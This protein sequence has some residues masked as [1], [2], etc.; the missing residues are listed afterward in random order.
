MMK[1]FQLA[2][3]SAILLVSCALAA[4]EVTHENHH[5]GKFLPSR[6]LAKRMNK[7]TP[8]F[9]LVA[10]KDS[11]QLKVVTRKVGEAVEGLK[12]AAASDGES[13]VRE[14]GGVS[15]FWDKTTILGKSA[16][17]PYGLQKN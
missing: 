9:R 11:N 2:V 14:Q 7:I 1:I 13:V 4:S 8:S 12:T 15:A 6:R 16:G 5:E 10:G 3:I 17:V